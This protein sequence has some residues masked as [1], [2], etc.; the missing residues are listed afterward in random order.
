MTHPW[1]ANVIAGVEEPRILIVG[2]ELINNNSFE[3][4][5]TN[6]N[7]VGNGMTRVQNSTTPFGNYVMDLEDDNAAAFEMVWQTIQYGSAIQGKSF[8]SSVW[9]KRG[10]SAN[11]TFS[12]NNNVDLEPEEDYTAREHW[13]KFILEATMPVGSITYF[14]LEIYPTDYSGGVS[15]TGHILLDNISVREILFDIELPLPYRGDFK[16][17]FIPALQSRYKLN[18][19]V[20]KKFYKGLIYY[21]TA[22]WKK[23]TAT[24]E[25]NRN[26]II[27]YNQI[28]GNDLIIFPHKDS[29][30]CYLVTAENDKVEWLWMAGVALGHEGGIELVGNE[31]YEMAPDDI[32]S[33]SYYDDFILGGEIVI[34]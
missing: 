30:R 6:W 8:I 19:Q 5:L 23:L 27:L 33:S 17:G 4:N 20:N 14:N 25:Q 7:Q 22:Y 18:N 10:G 21:Y 16:Q 32:V 31:L 1:V 29:D 13:K 2:P 15:E 34:S 24:Q 9:A 28:Q 26:K 3:E 12:M 11:Q